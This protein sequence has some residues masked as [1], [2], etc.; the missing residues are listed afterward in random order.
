MSDLIETSKE[1][2]YFC[3]LNSEAHIKESLGEPLKLPPAIL[4]ALGD[5]NHEDN[6]LYL[7]SLIT[8]HEYERVV[9]DNTYNYETDLNEFFIYSVYAPK[10]NRDW[11]WSQD[12]FV[13]VE[14]GAPGDP[15]YV[16]Y[17]DP[18]VYRPKAPLAETGFFDWNLGWYGLYL[19]Q[20]QMHYS[21]DPFMEEVNNEICQGS[22]SNPARKLN[23]ICYGEPVWV[24][25]YRGYVARA[26]G[27]PCPLVFFP[28]APCYH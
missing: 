9:R 17:S 6:L 28:T 19:K 23:E 14:M 13:T 7:F 3:A 12:C 1:S 26:K 8:G 27:S 24:E 22:G 10:A 11:M 20:G 25:K 18:K 21:Q 5:G 15:R 4:E 2:F 16:H